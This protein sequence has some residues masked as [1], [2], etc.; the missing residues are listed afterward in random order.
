MFFLSSLSV[1]C[2]CMMVSAAPQVLEATDFG[3]VADG[4]TDDG[5]A[6]QR[7]L[8]A[9]GA[10]Q[11]PVTLRFPEGRTVYVKTLPARYLFPWKGVSDRTLDGGGCT[12]LLDPWLRFMDLSE[13]RNITVRNIK[14]DFSPLPFADGVV[15]AVNRADGYLDV[16]LADYVKEAP[17]GGPTGEDG[18]QA[19]FAMLWHDGPYTPVSRHCWTKRME[20][21]G[22]G[23]TVRLFPAENFRAYGLIVPGAWWISLPV[24][25]IAH[26]YG[27][28]PC[29]RIMDNDTVTFED[30]ELWSAPWFAFGVSRNRGDITFRRVC[31]RPKPGTDRRMS[32]WRDGFHVKGNR[33]GLL[34]EDCIFAGMNDDAF[35]ISTHSSVVREIIDPAHIEVRQKFPLLPIPWEE[36]ATLVAV[37][38][39]AR[40]ILGTAKVLHVET[41]PSPPPIQGKPA[42][43]RATLT[44]DRPI[45]GLAKDTMVWDPAQCNPDTTLR[46]CRIDMSCRMQS[47]IRIEECEVN[48][49]LWFYSEQVEGG[50]PHH[51]VIRDSILRR[52][53]GNPVNTVVFSGAP[54]GDA[55][56]AGARPRAI[57]QVTIENNEIWGGLAVHGVEGLTLTGNRFLEEN[58]P[59]VVAGCYDTDIRDNTMITG[60]LMVTSPQ[61]RAG[62]R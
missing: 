23:R 14:V 37:D 29:F 9:A 10:A 32:V 50:F 25:G 60:E 61:A 42:A 18:E 57:H 34:W 26:R 6:I 1:L 39:A 43:P 3:L 58:A 17:T 36:G 27:P 55:A 35:N 31:I 12:F 24:P 2:S 5:P 21:R 52:G 15:T 22:D 40:R 4:A 49:L 38:E 28:G 53:R 16:R 59:A 54:D 45:A 13:S 48:G 47:P 33:G 7:L 11:G 30:V 56:D 62:R 44:L 41:G 51:V 19:F 8:N 20:P 46:R